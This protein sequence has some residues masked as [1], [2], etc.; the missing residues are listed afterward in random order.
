MSGDPDVLEVAQSRLVGLVLNVDEDDV[1]V[2]QGNR[3]EVIDSLDDLP[4]L[5]VFG[6]VDL[7]LLALWRDLTSE[8]H[9]LSPQWHCTHPYG[10]R[11][12]RSRVERR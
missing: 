2:H 10:G 9:S 1:V 3:P 11:A 6:G 8:S 12:S 4:A 5:L 7:D